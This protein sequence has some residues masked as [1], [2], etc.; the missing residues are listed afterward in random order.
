MMNKKFDLIHKFVAGTIILVFVAI[1]INLFVGITS[2]NVTFGVNGITDSRCVHGFVVMQ[3]Q[4]GSTTQ[5]LDE[6]GKGVPCSQ[7]NIVTQ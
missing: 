6:F 4:N 7:N 3:N 1:I 5:L 2:N